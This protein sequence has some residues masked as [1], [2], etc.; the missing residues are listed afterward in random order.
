M[1]IPILVLIG[2]WLRR[3]PVIGKLIDERFLNHRLRAQRAAGLVG[4]LVADALF[5]YRY[6]VQHV[7]DWDLLAVVISVAGIYFVLIAWFLFTE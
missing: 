7:F 2:G 1:V 5:G 3:V 6:L 4:F